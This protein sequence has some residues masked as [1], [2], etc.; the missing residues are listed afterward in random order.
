MSLTDKE[1]YDQP[2]GT[3]ITA[4]VKQVYTATAY[5]RYDGSTAYYVALDGR[6]IGTDTPINLKHIGTWERVEPT[7]AGDSK[8]D[9]DLKVTATPRAKTT[10][11]AKTAPK[12]ES[13]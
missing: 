9:P 1:L 6:E 8:P 12:K 7:P 11:K 10:P 13:E 3:Q 4:T 2:E 5:K